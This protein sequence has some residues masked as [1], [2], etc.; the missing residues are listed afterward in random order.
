MSSENSG[1]TTRRSFYSVLINLFGG[2][3][4]AVIAIPAGAYLL[5]KP[6]NSGADEMVEI[7]DVGTLEIGKPKEVV[8]FRTRVDGWKSSKEKTTAWVVKNSAGEVIAFDPICTHLG[9]A[10]HWEDDQKE[11]LCP[12]HTSSFGIDGKVLGGPA[13]RPLDRYV[14]KIEGGKLLI[15]PDLQKA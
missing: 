11:F 12:C 14:T 10:Y 4:A 8:Y 13:P 7:A 1:T 15:S 5:L 2:L 6:K 9:C 3:I